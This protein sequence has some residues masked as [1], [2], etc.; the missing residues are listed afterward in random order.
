M[1][2]TSDNGHKVPVDVVGKSNNAVLFLGKLPMISYTNQNNSWFDHNITKWWIYNGVLP[3]NEKFRGNVFP[4]GLILD[5][6]SARNL[7][8]HGMQVLERIN[9]LI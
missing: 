8:E 6:L 1:L 3:L 4:C 5:I 2:C 9:V 7:D